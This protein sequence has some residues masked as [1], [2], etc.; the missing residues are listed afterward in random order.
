MVTPPFGLE[1]FVMRR[2]APQYSM[3]T[4]YKSIFPFLLSPLT[5]MVLVFLFPV[6]AVGITAGA[7]Q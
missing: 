2:V 6:I 3:G 7:S 1:L 4:I 5:T